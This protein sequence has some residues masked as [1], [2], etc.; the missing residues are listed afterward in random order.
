VTR[1]LALLLVSA[2]ASAAEP[3]F[4]AHTEFDARAGLHTDLPTRATVRLRGPTGPAMHRVFGS[5][6]PAKL[7][8][9]LRDY[10]AREFGLLA[11]S[12]VEQ[13]F[14]E[15]TGTQSISMEGTTRLDWSQYKIVISN[16]RIGNDADHSDSARQP[17]AASVAIPHP[18]YRRISIDLRLPGSGKF[19]MSGGDYDVSL[20]GVHYLRRSRL[21]DGS[22]S[23]EA[24]FQSIRA[25]IPLSEARAAQQTLNAMY[26]DDL[27]LEVQEYVESDADVD[28]LRAR[29]FESA[30]ELN[31][32][33]NILLERRDYDGAIADY[34]A[35]YAL[36][37]APAI[38][39]D[40]GFAYY[41]KQD[42]KAARA[43]FQAA[44]DQD[45]ADTRALSGLGA[46]QSIEGQYAEAIATLSAVQKQAPGDSF[47]LSI[48]GW[49]Y[50]RL[51]DDDAALADA[52]AVLRAYPD[53][54]DMRALRA[55]IF[56]ARGD[57]EAS[58]READ[59]VLEAAPNDP[60]ALYGVS[61]IYRL[62]GQLDEAIRTMDRLIAIVP[63]AQ[64]HYLRSSL[65]GPEE[66]AAR[67]ADLDMA[68]RQDPRFQP[69]SL[70]RARLLSE[71]GEH[72]AAIAIYDQELAGSTRPRDKVRLLTLRGIVHAWSGKMAR[73]R[74][75]F[76]A[77]LAGQPD[78][79]AY[80]NHCWYLALA[81]LELKR[82]LVACEKAVE[83]EPSRA[84]YLDSRGFVLLQLK[85]YD[86][87][88][89]SFDGALA[90][91]ARLAHSLYFRGRA[92]NLRCNCSAG[93][94]DIGAAKKLDPGIELRDEPVPSG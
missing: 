55:R 19:S 56:H 48:R 10:A 63:T 52:D 93:D 16:V 65:H 79:A 26:R 3:L 27:Q 38:L 51:G 76:A 84:A 6:D 28:A 78:A 39:A 20:A 71:S 54:L 33:G 67:M 59:A 91:D 36:E 29:K 94:G 80:N 64:N 11:V 73:A 13:S 69:A 46:V 43:D 89:A 18:E 5:L 14:E 40:R 37:P 42:L 15:A 62:N 86:E 35:A 47:T 31:W 74:K 22:F 83:L 82:A 87:A 49:A 72:A 92:K 12:K 85:R 61:Y 60:T 41:W 21:E 75:D 58:L 57:R 4:E 45:P 24:V 32:R 53:Y 30:Y 7:D 66:I 9:Y 1:L 81:H 68:L 70:A 8:R 90:L 50:E 17:R 34:S 23:T 77:A 2:A 25:S 88:V 44:L